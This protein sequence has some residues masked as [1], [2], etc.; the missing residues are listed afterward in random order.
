ME[1][2]RHHLWDP[3][4]TSY[5]FVFGTIKAPVKDTITASYQF[6]GTIT[7]PVKDTITASYQFHG[8]IK[9]SWTQLNAVRV[10]GVMKSDA[11]M[12]SSIKL[13]AVMVSGVMKLD[14]AL[15]S[16][17]KLDAVRVSWNTEEQTPLCLRSPRFTSGNGDLPLG[18]TQCCFLRFSA[19]ID[20]SMYNIGCRDDDLRKY[21]LY[22]ICVIIFYMCVLYI[23]KKL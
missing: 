12:V 10:S 18:A 4:V 20:S 21:S 17:I 19:S 14:A 7:A 8:T 5:R 16:S 11:V 3:P 22:L 23:K 13:D 9:V 1:V 6:H 2:W 15:V